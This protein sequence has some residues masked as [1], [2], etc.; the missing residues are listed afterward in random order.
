MSTADQRKLPPRQPRQTR[1][2]CA[3]EATAT[4]QETAQ[5]LADKLLQSRPPA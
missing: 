1:E 4:L 3:V 5:E 2:E